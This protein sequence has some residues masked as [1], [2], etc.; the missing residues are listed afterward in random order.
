V[1]LNGRAVM[2]TGA[3]GAGKSALA[4]AL[5]GFG[6]QLVA[7]DQTL[8]S[9]ENGAL[10][11]RAPDA[12]SGLIEARGVGL[13]FAQPVAQAEI[14]LV[15]DLNQSETARLPESREMLILGVAVPV[16]HKVESTHFPA[17][18]LQYLKG[19]RKPV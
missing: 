1:A 2:I 18:I 10:V 19:G 13:L 3:S 16:L 14:V 7:D 4:L 9:C 17:A 8:V 11:A 15:V 6:A 5:M 12:I